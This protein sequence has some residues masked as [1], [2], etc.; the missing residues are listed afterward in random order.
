MK[1][2]MFS[3]FTLLLSFPIFAESQIQCGVFDVLNGNQSSLFVH[4]L[5]AGENGLEGWFVGE[6]ENYIF[7]AEVRH[8]GFV[9]LWLM[10]ARTWD[11]ATSEFNLD[12]VSEQSPPPKLMNVTLS[13]PWF[14]VF[15]LRQG[16][17]DC[18]IME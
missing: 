10:H 9:S 16:K 3:I 15:G 4:T 8:G 18:G 14:V 11:T 7:R 2:L 17:V 6:W 12:K 1:R 5:N 13:N